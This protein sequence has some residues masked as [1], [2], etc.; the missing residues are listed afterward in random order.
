MCL[1]KMMI[2]CLLSEE[3]KGK[4]ISTP[5][6]Q[7]ATLARDA[8]EWVLGECGSRPCGAQKGGFGPGMQPQRERRT[9]LRVRATQSRQTTAVQFS[10][11]HSQA[12][13][14]AATLQTM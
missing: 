4:Q 3:W 6:K 14:T 2:L 12:Q 11:S 1:L 7:G 10:G 8:A 9:I 5:E 13:W